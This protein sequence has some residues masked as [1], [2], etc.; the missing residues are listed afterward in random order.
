M[1]H[2]KHTH[3]LTRHTKAAQWQIR[4]QHHTPELE[5][6]KNGEEMC[7]PGVKFN[8][9]PSKIQSLNENHRN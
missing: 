1:H 3:G 9:T 4:A 2:N 5:P 7:L 8:L 6:L